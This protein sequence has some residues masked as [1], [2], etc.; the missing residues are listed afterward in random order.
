MENNE[1]DRSM[2][3]AI[4]ILAGLIIW[5]FLIPGAAKWIL[6]AWGIAELAM[7]KSKKK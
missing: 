5:G 1:L 2:V 3:F 7:R 4:F 6:L